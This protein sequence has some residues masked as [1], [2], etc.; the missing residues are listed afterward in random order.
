MS[1]KPDYDPVHSVPAWLASNAVISAVLNMEGDK[2][3]LFD[4]VRL[5]EG[6][7]DIERGE[8]RKANHD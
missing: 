6:M 8:H 4:V 7:V 2:A 1:E 3:T 5:L